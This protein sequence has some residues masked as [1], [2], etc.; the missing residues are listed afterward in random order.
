VARTR[1]LGLSLFLSLCAVGLTG[2]EG[3]S[4]AF[5]DATLCSGSAYS[6]C[7]NAG[8]TDHGFGPNNGNSY[9]GAYAGHN[10]TNY[11][12]Y[13]LQTVNGA[14][15]PGYLL[16]NGSD[17]DN[18]A[19][20][21]GVLVNGGPVRGSI[22][23]WEV[24]TARPSGHVA[25]VEAVNADGSITV[26]QD[27]W[28]AG[29]F[30]WQNLL[31]GSANWPNHFI[32]FKDL[33]SAAN[34]TDI[35]A[36]NRQDFGSSSTA[37]H[38]VNGSNWGQ[39][40][41]NSGSALIQ[42]NALWDFA[43]GDLNHDGRGDVWS[44]NRNPGGGNSVV[45]VLNGLNPMQYLQAGNIV[46]PGVSQDWSFALGDYNGDGTADIY[47][48]NRA[49]GT[50]HT[51]VRVINGANWGQYLQA[52]NIVLPATDANWAFGVGNF[53]GDAMPDIYAINR[54][55]TGSNSTALH[56]INGANWGLYLMN[57]GS[58]LI[59]TN[60]LWDF[61]VGDLNGD[62]RDDLWAFNRNPGGSNTAVHVL[63]GLNPTQYLQAG[64]II[65]PGTDANWSFR[66]GTFN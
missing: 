43:V 46:L 39:Y 32:H 36:I 23:Q 59:Q 7:T 60:A 37:V 30:S 8:Y 1:G 11:V 45:H 25:Y 22:A 26:S 6:S 54:Q 12:A 53:N 24:T 5:A 19:G 52:G 21:H 16:G 65:L 10:C 58:A 51:E 28:S 66:A 3:A 29:P 18:T 15:T 14:P 56:V 38:A 62:G 31:P 57:S 9:W 2:V 47:A 20:S 44:F 40:L 41:M 50:S 64:N 35:Y 34:P 42:T 4:P 13:T 27:N 55:D 17:W 33:P 63:N 49:P 61:A 48:I